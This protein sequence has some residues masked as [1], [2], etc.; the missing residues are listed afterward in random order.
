MTEIKATL[1]KDPEN[2]YIQGNYHYGAL[3]ELSP[4]FY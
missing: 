4:L 3:N 2:I 1:T